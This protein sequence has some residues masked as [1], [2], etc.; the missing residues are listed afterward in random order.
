MQTPTPAS[1]RPDATEEVERPMPVAAHER[2]REEIEEPAE[3]ALHPVP[4]PAVL[5]GAVVD[6]HLGD[7][8][9]PVAREHRDEAM[10]LAV[11]PQLVRDLAPHRLE[12]AVHVVQ[13][14]TGDPSRHAVE[15]P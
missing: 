4:A 5:A 12:A 3:V 7:P 10:Q 1:S 15:D 14:D 11:Q 13:P 9:A 8:E 2:H 6:G